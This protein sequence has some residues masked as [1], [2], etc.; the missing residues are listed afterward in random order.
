MRLVANGCDFIG[1]RSESRGPV[2]E[3]SAD[4][5]LR[6][7]SRE[8]ARLAPSEINGH[9]QQGIGTTARVGEFH[10]RGDAVTWVNALLVVILYG[11]APW[12]AVNL[13]DHYLL[14]RGRYSLRDQFT[15][16]WVY[17][18]WGARGLIAYG[19]GFA[20]SL[21]FFT[22]ANVYTAPLAAR[23]GGVDLRWLVSLTVASAI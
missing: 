19:A 5:T 22:A 13:I 1:F 20:A 4:C 3:C 6:F 15:P 23:L 7:G 14:R 21:P 2:A 12:S 9:V 17:G 11:L 10:D 18:A 8:A 16:H